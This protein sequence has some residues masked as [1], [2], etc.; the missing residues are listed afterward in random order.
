[1]R[2]RNSPLP[3]CSD[4]ETISWPII[5]SGFPDAQRSLEGLTG[6]SFLPPPRGGFYITLRIQKDEEQAAS[7]LLERDGILVHPGY[8]YDISPDHLVMTFIDEPEAVRGHFEK[9]SEQV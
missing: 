3:T 9:I 8:F 1:M 6:L 2:S 5:S 7:A 4:R